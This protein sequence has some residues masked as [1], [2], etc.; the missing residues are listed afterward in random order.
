MCSAIFNIHH[1]PISVQYYMLCASCPKCAMLYL[2]YTIT[3]MALLYIMIW[4]RN[5]RIM[6]SIKAALL[7]QKYHNHIVQLPVVPQAK[8]CCTCCSL[9]L[10]QCKQL[11]N[12]YFQVWKTQLWNN[13]SHY[14]SIA[15]QEHRENESW[16]VFVWFFSLFI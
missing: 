9:F 5:D 14:V 3:S 2:M 13:W 10:S 1:I 11:N 6:S 16:N 15:K 12:L 7:Q 4:H 8:L